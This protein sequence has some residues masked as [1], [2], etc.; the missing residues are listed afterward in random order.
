MVVIAGGEIVTSHA[1]SGSTA[2]LQLESL[3]LDIKTLQQDREEN[4]KEFQQ[5]QAT[6]NRNFA[7]M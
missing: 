5:F 7:T 1:D 6:V 3:E 4:R 2:E